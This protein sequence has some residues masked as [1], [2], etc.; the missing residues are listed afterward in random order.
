MP[1]ELYSPGRKGN[2][3]V[4]SEDIL[5]LSVRELGERIR[6][7]KLSPVELAE[8][9]LERSEKLGPKLN[10]YATVTRGLALRQAHAA[11][12]EIAAGHYR[13]PLHGVPYAAKD[14]V[15]VEGYPT[16]WGARPYF[17]QKFDFNATVIER[18]NHAGAVLVG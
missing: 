5:F 12:K 4:V 15:A 7:R 10:A 17:T 3:E 8:G 13:G 2:P 18:L 11:E 16:T 9:Y 6:A 14:L 1:P